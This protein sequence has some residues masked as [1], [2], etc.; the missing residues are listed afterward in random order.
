MKLVAF[1]IVLDGLP[2]ISSIFTALQSSR[3]DWQWIV[4]EGVANNVLC[5][6]HCRKIEP[7]LSRDG[8]TE[9]L[10]S[11]AS[12]PRV[13]IIRQELWEGK[14]AMCNRVL[15]ELSEPCLLM[16]IDSDEYWR[17]D[18][19]E[20]L[21]HISESWIPG[22]SAKF[23]CRFFVGPSI[24]TQGTDCYGNMSYEWVRAW[25]WQKGMR[26]TCHCP[27]QMDHQ[28]REMSREET[29][30][31]GLVFDHHAYVTEKQVQFKCDYY[32]YGNILGWI[33]LQGNQVWPT[34]LDAFLPWVDEKVLAVKI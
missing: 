20:L 3:T 30:S 5:S 8:T 24:I 16:Q 34:K 2:W 25:S 21:A 32:G 4:V 19:L 29:K 22:D 33:A 18:Q 15:E 1:T 23:Y 11:I 10:D 9:F 13:K 28:G 26:F 31:L 12:H 17:P 6:S 27:P 7:R 14:I